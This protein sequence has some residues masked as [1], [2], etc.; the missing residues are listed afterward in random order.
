MI[1]IRRLGTSW[2]PTRTRV[3]PGPTFARTPPTSTSVTVPLQSR[4]G[5]RSTYGTS[6]GLSKPISI[7]RSLGCRYRSAAQTVPGSPSKAAIAA[8]SG[9]SSR[10]PELGACR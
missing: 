1:V 10:P 5:R 9:N 6:R 7:H 3:R 8:Y 4:T 2:R